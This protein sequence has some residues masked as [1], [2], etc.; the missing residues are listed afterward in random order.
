MASTPLRKW[1][2]GNGFGSQVRRSWR[3]YHHAGLAW[4][5]RPSIGARQLKNI[6]SRCSADAGAAMKA[7]AIANDPK[8]KRHHGG[9]KAATRS[10]PATLPPS[11]AHKNSRRQKMEPTN[12]CA[13]FCWRTRSS[14]SDKKLGWTE[15]TIS[16]PPKCKSGG[17]AARR[18]SPRARSAP[19]FGSRRLR[20]CGDVGGWA[21]RHAGSDALRTFKSAPRV[22]VPKPNLNSPAEILRCSSPICY[23]PFCRR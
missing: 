12:S 13:L 8:R 1:L 6:D 19:A 18:P 15:T 20:R 2:S 9:N 10:L 23:V 3:P 5:V 22:E 7:R 16:G 11:P 4:K 14:P 21:R 17:L